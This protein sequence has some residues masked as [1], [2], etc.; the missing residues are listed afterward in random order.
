MKVMFVT[1]WMEMGG[2]E[3]NIVLLTKEFTSLGH[4]VLVVSSGGVLDSD[5]HLNKGESS[6][7][8][9]PSKNFFSSA[10]KLKRIIQAWD[11]DIIHV[12][13]ACGAFYLWV[14][15]KLLCGLGKR[16][17]VVSS[18]MGLQNSPDESLFKTQLRNYLMTLGAGKILIISPAIGKYLRKLPISGDRLIEK[19][20]VGIRMPELLTD[21]EKLKV[22]KELMVGEEKIIITIG[23][24]SPRKSHELF[25][26]AASKVLTVRKDVR[27][28]IVGEG[29]LRNFL[30]DR[31]ATLGIQANVHLL[32]MRKDVLRLLSV[33]DICVKPG[34]V[35]GFVG[36]TVME[37]QSLGVPVIAFDTIDVRLVI[38]DGVTGLIVPRSDIEKL[39][40]TIEMLLA[41]KDVANKIGESGR[42][43]IRST[44][45]IAA[46]AEGLLSIY[47]DE[48]K[49][50][51][52]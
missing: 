46:V 47:E 52:K 21:L 10:L 29:E 39:A 2:V 30:E 35:E 11:P 48:V 40:D 49:S 34:I 3:T 7:I 42:I 12:F 8:G 27:F 1:N 23:T 26:D 25:I 36:I 45:S 17:P 22:R 38:Q 31:I 43:F 33:A 4:K 13:S 51:L 9:I 24:L 41:D 5:V 20:V 15:H 28:F 16:P 18:V 19:K 32:G 37:A 14:A 44:F 50:Y 6:R